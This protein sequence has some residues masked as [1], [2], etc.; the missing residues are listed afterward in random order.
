MSLDKT[1]LVAS[2]NMSEFK[3]LDLYS[4]S[5]SKTSLLL[6]FLILLTWSYLGKSSLLLL[7][8]GCVFGYVVR[9]NNA[10]QNTQSERN[11][12][13]AS[14]QQKVVEIIESNQI[15]PP[16]KVS[17]TELAIS[18]NIDAS[19]SK[20]FDL[21]M[22]DF[23]HLYYDP[24]NPNNDTE[25]TDQVRK[26]L[27]SMAMNL[28]LCFQKLDKVDL[29]IMSGFAISNT[30]IVHLRE[31]RKFV[32]AHQ[33]LDTYCKLNETSPFVYTTN[34]KTQAQTLRALSRL[35]FSRL[36][37]NSEAESGIL[38]AYFSEMWA[39]EVFQKTLDTICDPDWINCTI[40][41]Y[42]TEVNNSAE[43][44]DSSLFQ[45]LASSID[46]EVAGLAEKLKEPSEDSGSSP[47]S[48][49]RASIS[50]NRDAE[51]L[52]SLIDIT[53]GIPG[54]LS[55][56]SNTDT[57]ENSSRESSFER[58]LATSVS[59]K[60]PTINVTDSLTPPLSPNRA[61]LR[62]D[63]SAQLQKILQQQSEIFAEF[64]AFLEELDS[65]NLLRF[66]LQ[67][68]SFRKI[69]SDEVNPDVIQADALRIYNLY[70]GETATSPI[71]VIPEGLVRRCMQEIEEAPTGNCF[72]TVQEYIFGILERDYYDDFIQEMQVQGQDL[73]LIEVKDEKKNGFSRVKDEIK[74]NF[75][76]VMSL[77]LSH[78]SNQP[79][80]SSPLSITITSNTPS[81]SPLLK[82]NSYDGSSSSLSTSHISEGEERRHK[83]SNTIDNS[84]LTPNPTKTEFPPD[85]LDI[86][87]SQPI[88]NL[89][90]RSRSLSTGS[91]LQNVEK[92][93]ENENLHEEQRTKGLEELQNDEIK[94]SSH[95]PQKDEQD[96]DGEEQDSPL[97]EDEDDEK[98]PDIMMNLD[99]VRIRMSDVSESS[100]NKYIYLTKS[101]AYMIEVEQ[102]GSTG[103]IMT[104]SFNDFEKMHTELVEEFPKAEK[105]SMPRLRLKKN[106]EACKA[107]ERY[108]NILLSDNGLCQSKPL[109]TFM[110]RD[111]VPKEMN[112]ADTK[113][114]QKNSLWNAK[115][116]SIKSPSMINLMSKE[117]LGGTTIGN[118]LRKNSS[119][120]LSADLSSFDITSEN[121]SGL[122]RKRAN[123]SIRVRTS[124][125]TVTSSSW[126]SSTTVTTPTS[127]LDDNESPN[128]VTTT[129]IT[130]N[131]ASDISDMSLINSKVVIIEEQSLPGSEID[132]LSPTESPKRYTRPNKQLTGQDIDLLID[133]MFAVVEEIFDLSEKSQWHLRKTVLSVL[134]E[135]VR[136]SFSQVIKQSFLEAIESSFTEEQAVNAI[137]KLSNS[138]WP[139]GIWADP[140]T[141]RSEQEKLQTKEE[142]KKLLLKK[143]VPDSLKQVMG[144][145]NSRVM[146]DGLVDGFLAE[147]EVVRGMGVSILESITK[148]VISE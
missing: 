14:F 19:L 10:A 35:M 67:V 87:E 43:E 125:E 105:V 147:K 50:S 143:L 101:L 73:S 129:P 59:Q 92:V 107:L 82:N 77:P 111:G 83:R 136:R 13:L 9:V 98:E 32:S 88:D 110:K 84:S 94:I 115:K 53:N 103:W 80:T 60:N 130:C 51:F 127:N 34:K 74:N 56:N 100:P 133:T 33:T 124:I 66:W 140:A 52:D 109:Q 25:F 141:L 49:N 120:T 122:P 68:D 58:N 21:I 37:P 65:A 71:K 48:S 7:G 114:I 45:Q 135:V 99:G 5:A 47:S 31:Y 8:L 2:P 89:K 12:K 11:E 63:K 134:R 121:S 17:S 4:S 15:Q 28:S 137:N 97:Y 104:R 1:T 36:L 128:S 123:D 22:R 146:V 18:P 39:N 132:H 81:K 62:S 145:E 116:F 91:V 93:I 78:S 69:A 70:F 86:P 90:R 46:E 102:P 42:L 55:I 144:S 6:Y 57:N 26:S 24:I 3:S 44:N 108:L 126:D 16:K 40:V 139:N 131:P 38:M 76:R 30:F 113:G 106:H 148:L 117:I 23:V 41:D 29:G 64:M 119:E 61:F 54:S 96:E 142:A 85:V 27:N 112:S 75:K 20:L 138:F 79:L 95:E 72:I 118:R